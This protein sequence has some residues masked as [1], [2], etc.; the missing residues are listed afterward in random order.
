[1]ALEPAGI[2]LEAEGFAAYLKKLNDI[3]KKQQEVFDT[4]FKDTQKSFA[5]VTK[6]AQKYEKELKD[7]ANTERK[8][9]EEAKKLAVAQKTAAAAQRQAAISTANAVVQTVRMIGQAGKAAFELG[10]LGATFE[11]QS[12][13][14]DNLA[15]SFGQ[16]GAAI[17]SAIV[18]ASRG[19]VSDLRAI[20]TA[21]EALL[22]GVAKTPEEFEKFT[23]AALVLGRT[24]GLSASESITRFTTALGRESLLR[25]DD[26]GTKA[27]EV[28][29]EIIRLAQSELGKLP[30]QLSRSERSAIFIQA[31]LNTTGANV[32]KI[33]D[34]AGDALE[35]FGQI[36]AASE[37]IKT[38]VGLLV[39]DLDEASG[40]SKIF[41]KVLQSIGRRFRGLRAALGF[42]DVR[43]E[44]AGLEQEL[45]SLEKLKI[46][47][48]F[49][50]FLLTGKPETLEELDQRIE[51][52]RAEIEQLNLQALAEDEARI[53]E[54]TQGATDSLQDQEDALQTNEA[55]IN[56]LGQAIQQA[57]QLQLSFA[58]AIE[59]TALKLARQQEDVVRKTAR[60]V[61]RLQEDQAEARADL[62]ND[63]IKEL[64]KFNKNAAKQI[65]DAEKNIAKEQQKAQEDV[66][67]A[68]ADAARDRLR[69]QEKLQRELRQ[70]Q[71][72]FNLSQL[73]SERR[74]QLS[75]KR[76]RAEGDILG[77]QQLREDQELARQEEKE[78]FALQQKETQDNA[79]EQAKDQGQDLEDRIK[80]INQ[81]A[82]ERI[83]D[84]K[85]NL[86]QQRAELL[87]NFDQRIADQ[88]QAQAE[89]RM[90]QQ[91]G[92]DEQAEDRAI[93]LQRTEEDRRI[94]EQRQLEDLGRSLASQK[95]LTEEG[96]TAIASEIEKVFGQEGVADIIFSGFAARTESG[97]TELFNNVAEI[98]ADTTISPSSPAGFGDSG[99]QPGGGIGQSF[100]HGGVIQGP[101]GSPQIVQA[102]AGET[103]LP[104]HK[105]SFIMP[106]PVVPSQIL[107]IEMSG[108]FSIN[109]G[110]E[111]SAGVVDA[112]VVE[113]ADTL[114]ITMKRLAR[115]NNI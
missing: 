14:L 21:N 3:D 28:N 70:A 22:L 76:L 13:G 18:R 44:I 74:F 52:V 7:L 29:A 54:A 19:A 108:G 97:F 50:R 23:R 81:D 69:A 100:E 96:V 11:A 59:D 86:E 36:E 10:K 98:V 6:A 115:R 103:V 31:A 82:N 46:V 32:E 68:Q 24:V 16:S 85:A 40:A 8:A 1:M 90:E 62:L 93:A 38:Q 56:A 104:T 72:R 66:K 77:L 64:E 89:A 101:I 41:A 47:S 95:D 84:L 88:L 107:S 5:Q 80:Q 25:L 94:S 20:S 26:F 12:I 112:A 51:K 78:N 83:N 30:E 73:Q 102:H 114:E 34:E 105:Q 4:K 9:R 35:S 58:R 71:D 2:S 87:A 48:P 39:K 57:E 53:A 55:A 92:F 75:E 111:A 67:R 79:N 45:I 60:Q 15:A 110:E 33:G 49:S 106:A 27:S 43:D 109:G 63:Q 65:A 91:R 61:G 42:G 37:N 99:I 113:M 17:Q